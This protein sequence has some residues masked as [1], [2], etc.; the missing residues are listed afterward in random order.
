MTTR[1]A[2]SL[3]EIY[4]AAGDFARARECASTPDQ[5]KALAAALEAGGHDDT[6]LEMLAGRRPSWIP[7]D[8]D[9][10]ARLARA[11]IARG[12]L[13]AAAEYLTVE[14]AGDDAQLLFTVAELRLRG[15]TPEEGLAI[16]R[17]LLE[18]ASGPS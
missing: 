7:D 13:Q 1:S 2:S 5:L 18:R 8:S 10:R 17:R 11:F 6:A 14:T 4:V 16:V 12:N 3:L 9:L 15:E